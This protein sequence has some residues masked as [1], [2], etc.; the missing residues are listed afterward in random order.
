MNSPLNEAAYMGQAPAKHLKDEIHEWA[1]E[2]IVSTKGASETGAALYSAYCAWAPDAGVPIASERG[3]LRALGNVGVPKSTRGGVRVWLNVELA[4]AWQSHR[5]ATF[6]APVDAVAK[7]KPLVL[8]W[9]SA[10]CTVLPDAVEAF[11]DLHADICAFHGAAVPTN[12]LGQIFR[13]VSGLWSSRATVYRDG[14][15]SQLTLWHGVQ[16]RYAKGKAQSADVIKAIERASQRR[17]KD[18]PPQSAE[19]VQSLHFHRPQPVIA[20][21]DDPNEI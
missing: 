14:V 16:L 17:L 21:Y 13:G 20:Q 4:P 9:M 5:G 7:Y 19:V 18:L 11:E 1:A 15:R 8:Q 10:R 12:Y 2:C 3:F 6:G